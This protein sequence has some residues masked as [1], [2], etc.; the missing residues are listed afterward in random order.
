[1]IDFP[2][3]PTVGQSFTAAG[4]TWVWD[5]Q[6]WNVNSVAGSQFIVVSSTPP[7]NPTIGSLWWDSVGG[8]LYVWYNDEN[9]TQWVTAINQGFGGLYLALAGGTLTGPLILAADPTA[10]LGAAT[11]EYVDAGDTATAA[12]VNASIP[13]KYPLN[14]NRI[15]NG[16]MRISQR[17]GGASGTAYAYTVDRWQYAGTVAGQVTWQQTSNGGCPGFPYA[18]RA[19][20]SSAHTVVATDTFYIVQS[21]EADMVSDFQ[22]GATGAQPV[23]LS[24]WVYC[25]L[26]GIFGGCLA[27][28]AGTRSYPFTFSIP[29]ANTW[30]KIA[31]TIPGDTAGTWVMSGN[32]GAASLFFD[33]GSGANYRAP[34]GAWVAGNRIGANGAVNLIATNGAGYL[35][36]GVKLEI[37]SVA[38]PFNQQS[39]AKSMVDCQRYYQTGQLYLYQGGANYTA[40]QVVAT[41]SLAPVVPRASPTMAVTTNSNTNMGAPTLSYQ[42]GIFILTGTVPSAGGYGLNCNFSANAEL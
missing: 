42:A 16:D 9:S 25:S 30:T 32:G 40:G 35:V 23:T 15:I 36:T 3:A 10:A 33:L 26:T 8:Q 28:Y 37:G 7:T 19:I 18:L 22:W 4:V 39:L 11:K 21:I 27:N 38:T 12:S 6:K 1:M 31:V 29:T 34:A 17:N 13:A 41:S 24:F 2:N 5:G 14:S 20:S